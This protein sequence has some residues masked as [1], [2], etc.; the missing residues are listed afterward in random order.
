MAQ[1]RQTLEGQIADDLAR[2]DLSSQI[3]DGVNAAIRAYRFERLGFNEAYRQ[4]AT[5]SASS[6]VLALSSV[7]V[8][9]RKIDRLRL[10]MSTNN[11][12]ELWKRD[13]DWLM[14]LQETD[15]TATPSE[16]CLY[17][18]RVYFDSKPP[19]N[20]ELLIDGIKELTT[21]ASASYSMGDT[22]AWFNDGRELIRH[23]AKREVYAHVLK[24]FELASMAG[25]A[26]QEALRILKCEDN[27]ER[28]TGFLRP[29]QF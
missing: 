2:G 14:T 18:N 6:N 13:Y 20:S 17:A 12:M 15:A 8:R 7:A 26:E 27:E 21:N 22:S 25:A 9:F 5:L 3:T 19:T 1:T 4:T 23:R 28:S 16:Y 29:T 11:Y 24:D 10:K